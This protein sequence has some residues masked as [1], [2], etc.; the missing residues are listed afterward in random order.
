MGH[1]SIFEFPNK[2]IN[3]YSIVNHKTGAI[4]KSPEIISLSKTVNCNPHT[5][6][7]CINTMY[8]LQNKKEL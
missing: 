8:S 7:E 5:L 2:S 1:G 4:I 6:L 3:F